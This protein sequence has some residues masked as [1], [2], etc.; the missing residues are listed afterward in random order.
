MKKEMLLGF[1]MGSIIVLVSLIFLF[2]SSTQLAIF[3]QQ[4]L[5]EC[6]LQKICNEDYYGYTCGECYGWPPENPTTYDVSCRDA[7]R[8]G[9]YCGDNWNGWTSGTAY[10]QDKYNTDKV[11]CLNNNC[12]LDPNKI[13]TYCG[14][15]LEMPEPET[16]IP[17]D[18]T[19]G[20]E[21]K[22][23][24]NSSNYLMLGV[25]GIFALI[26]LIIGIVVISKK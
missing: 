4:T 20:Y 15:N 11:V 26:T 19:P 3:E 25:L 2:L 13:P 8:Y 24:D 21:E 1:V 18:I 17:Q 7:T 10:C 12:K 23:Q 16:E 9:A 22:E 14:G 5:E 6:E